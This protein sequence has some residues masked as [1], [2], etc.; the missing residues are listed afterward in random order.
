MGW[1]LSFYIYFVSAD[2]VIAYLCHL[3]YFYV[4]ICSFTS[5]LAFLFPAVFATA[6]LFCSLLSSFMCKFVGIEETTSGKMV[7][8][9]IWLKQQIYIVQDA[10]TLE[11]SAFK[12]CGSYP[13]GINF[14]AKWKSAAAFAIVAVVVG[15]ACTFAL[16]F[17][18]CM[19]ISDGMWKSFGFLLIVNTLFQG[20]TFLFL[21][22]NACS[23]ER[24][25]YQWGDGRFKLAAGC[26]LA[27]GGNLGIAAT[28]LWA[29]A[30]LITLKTP[31]P[32]G[33]SMN[34]AEEMAKADSEEGDKVADNEE[35]KVVAAEEGHD[36][37]Q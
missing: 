11:W 1:A 5:E 23:D 27:S 17:A 12:G 26:Q 28:I 24:E 9:G 20:L 8:I 18:A 2:I 21:S 19:T 10:E 35:D 32:S 30:G 34:F 14:D 33:D 13:D 36:A 25:L 16:Y 31:N 7:N 29:V 37:A 3:L 22:S 6:G 15:A 4:C